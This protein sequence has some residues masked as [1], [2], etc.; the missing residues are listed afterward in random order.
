MSQV[1]TYTLELF[2]PRKGQTI[3]INGHQFLNGVCKEN[4]PTE[5]ASSLLQV[6]S[7]YD[8]FAAGTEEYKL[9]EA[10]DKAAEAE[11]GAD[12]VHEGPVSGEPDPVPSDAGSDGAGPAEEPTVLSVE[13]DAAE[14]ETSGG[15]SSGDGHEDTGFVKFEELADIPEPTEPDSVGDPDIK[16]AMLKLDPNNPDH[17]AKRGRDA[18]KPKLSAVEN[19]HGKAGLTRADLEAAL[20]GWNRDAARV[21]QQ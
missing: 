7:Y 2:G 18:G 17:W 1:L 6:M 20:P 16:R 14:T 11:N 8:A 21:S 12:E 3:N 4:I 15:D 19:A 13:P 10:K 9:A 5:A